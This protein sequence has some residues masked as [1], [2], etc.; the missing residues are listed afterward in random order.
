MHFAS[1]R[2]GLLGLRVIEGKHSRNIDYGEAGGC[3]VESKFIWAT[4]QGM[5]HIQRDARDRVLVHKSA[6][7]GHHHG[8]VTQAD[9]ANLQRTMSTKRKRTRCMKEREERKSEQRKREK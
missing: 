2:V 7:A 9:A 8:A 3:A 1:L 4:R 5:L 6:L